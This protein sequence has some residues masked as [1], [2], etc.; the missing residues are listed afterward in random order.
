MVSADGGDGGAAARADARRI[1]REGYDR[2]ADRYTT[3]SIPPS[4]GQTERFLGEVVAAVPDGAEVLDLGCGQ[5]TPVAAALARRCRVTGVDASRA[6]LERA[7]AAVPGAAFVEADIAAYERSPSSV[8]AVTAFYSLTHLP[9]DDQAAVIAGIGTWLRPG[10]VFC[11]TLGGGDTLDEVEPEWLG[12]PMFFA[13]FAPETNRRLLAVAGLTLV[14]D[15]VVDL[16][17]PDGIATFHYVIARKP[18]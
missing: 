10:G 17:E 13:G 6:Q 11:A 9:R 12:V 4:G 1:V 16:Q 18:T 5:G 15:E 7:R 14:V 8:D 3:W 2:I